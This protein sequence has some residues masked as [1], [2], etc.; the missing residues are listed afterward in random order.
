MTY[1]GGTIGEMYEGKNNDEYHMML[2][3]T[4]IIMLSNVKFNAL[5]KKIDK[6][7]LQEIENV[8]EEARGNV[9]CT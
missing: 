9:K 1:K 7:K 5:C 3:V 8:L 2:Q 4:R 6:G